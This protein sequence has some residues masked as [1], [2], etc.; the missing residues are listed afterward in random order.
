MSI[1]TNIKEEREPSQKKIV[2]QGDSTIYVCMNN[3]Y[4][5]KRNLK[6]FARFFFG[7]SI[8]FQ[9]NRQSVFKGNKKII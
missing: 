2:L 6:F 7:D 8:L 5:S 3:Q 1:S 4:I 9:F